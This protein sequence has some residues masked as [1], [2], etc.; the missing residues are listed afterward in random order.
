MTPVGWYSH[1]SGYRARSALENR[2]RQLRIQRSFLLDFEPNHE[3]LLLEVLSDIYTGQSLTRGSTSITASYSRGKFRCMSFAKDQSTLCS[4]D[5]NDCSVQ[6]RVIALVDRGKVRCWH[7]F[8]EDDVF[9]SNCDSVQ[10][11]PVF[12][13]DSIKT[14]SRGKDHVW[15]EVGPSFDRCISLLD[16]SDQRF[17]TDY[18]H[19][20]YENPR[21]WNITHY[22][23]TVMVP[24]RVRAATSVAVNS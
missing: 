1:Q 10:W 16:S 23:S 2:Q 3:D 14:S 6:H 21:V 9:D 24:A 12:R 7:V 5:R 22:S 13:T 15:V 4:Q 19:R 8:G 18:Q 17:R 11:A 20:E